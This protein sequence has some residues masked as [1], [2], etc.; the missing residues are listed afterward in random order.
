[1]TRRLIA[2]LLLLSL[3]AALGCQRSWTYRSDQ[4]P[5]VQDGALVA[6]LRPGERASA[7]PIEHVC[8]TRVGQPGVLQEPNRDELRAI[9]A[10]RLRDDVE[11][12][13]LTT[14]TTAV[15]WKEYALPGAL[16]GGVL[17]AALGFLIGR[18]VDDLDG[19]DAAALGLGVG[20]GFAF[21]GTLI[22]GGVGAWQTSVDADYRLD[23]LGALLLDP[24]PAE[25]PPIPP[26]RLP[27]EA[28][29]EEAPAPPPSDEAPPDEAPPD[30]PPPSDPASPQEG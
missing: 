22:G 14:D 7:W 13:H 1:M 9:A 3:T 27:D 8:V 21:Y 25:P 24:A 26:R 23:D 30:E 4:L 2:A 16:I 20:L 18:T 19:G 6:P 15:V 10:G 11:S 12:I 29:A 28:P 17:G 5:T